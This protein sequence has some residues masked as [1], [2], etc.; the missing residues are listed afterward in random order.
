VEPAYRDDYWVN[1][2][3]PLPVFDGRPIIRD[4]RVEIPPRQAPGP[5]SQ[6]WAARIISA[7]RDPVY[8]GSYALVANTM[9]TSVIGAVYW[10]VAA[11]L[12][13]A[14]D[15]GRATA[16]I[17]GLML[18]ATLSQLNLSNTLMR[19]LPQM[20]A[21]SAR[22][23]IN[24]TY[25]V[26]TLT[27]VAGSVIFVTVLPRLSSEWRFIG[28]SAFF[29]VIFAVSVIVWEIF[30]LQ[31]AA[32]VGL[33]RPVAVPIE[34]VV[35]SLAKLALL[36]IAVKVLG[37]T[38]VLF[39]WIIPLI[40]LIPGIN[41]LIFRRCLKD[42]RPHDLT[43][44]MRARQLARFASIDFGGV[45]CSQITA[46]ALPLLVI[47]VLGPAAAGSFYI[48][49]LITSGVASVGISFAT[50][51][52]VE[53]SAAPHRLPEITR[54][55]L[56]R[57]VLT[58]GP[59][60]LLLVFGARLILRVYGGDYIAK[61][62]TLFELLA[63]TLLP[64]CI[65]T[66][67]YSLD[68]IAGK[69]IRSTLSQLAIAVISLGG[70]GLLFGRLGVNAV[71]VACLT[72]DTAVALVRL[73]TVLTALRRR[74]GAVAPP[75]SAALRPV[76][77]AE[78]PARPQPVADRPQPVADRPQPVADRPQPVPDRQNYVGRHRASGPGRTQPTG[79]RQAG[80]R[81]YAG[82]EGENLPERALDR[83]GHPSLLLGRDLRVER[84]RQQL[85]GS[86]LGD[87]EITRP[88]TE[89]P[90]GR[91]QVHGH[92]VVDPGTNSLV[93]QAAQDV[94]PARNSDH[95][96]M[97]HVLIAGCG[98]G[99]N[100]LGQVSEQLGITARG[101]PPRQVSRREAAELGPQHNRLEGVEPGVEPDSE[102]LVAT[103]G[104][105]VTEQANPPRQFGGLGQHR[106][107]V[108]VG[109]EILARVETHP[110][111]QA[112][113]AGRLAALGGAMG[114]GGVFDNDGPARGG[115]GDG[116]HRRHLAEEV[117]R[118]HRP[119]LL[120]QGR[121]QGARIE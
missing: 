20:G 115:G 40:F 107:G 17:S 12:Y 60:T 105:M 48:A 33:Q 43:P 14:V 106:P 8:R 84:Q 72:A 10:A 6:N 110:G 7:L 100:D 68:R 47:S 45:I 26:S 4:R 38:D 64:F 1:D 120:A 15:L 30:T 111:Q 79:Q 114:L 78:V 11:H 121:L 94:I 50:G 71:G 61:T 98:P 29:A 3:L 49:S 31:D 21:M 53:A 34:N 91:L 119:G 109:T 42:R 87:R 81:P 63:L 80:R 102:V 41:W 69:P 51:L 66:V 9:G 2:T 52:M 44:P 39:S 93:V 103:L 19:F 25:V 86:S 77:S 24:T 46:N 97:P 57:C 108:A 18:V 70:S 85:T 32:L 112:E 54:G 55:A 28:D 13:S 35:Y 73:P 83:A 117:H 95:V 118:D 37:S 90:E 82:R 22:R 62:A 113:R 59:A 116:G 5:E 101:L 75:A 99:E 16:L 67:A 65:E 76:P 104:A 58:M 74:P 23:L 27:A 96:Q 92:R 88:V 56:K 36:V 89:V